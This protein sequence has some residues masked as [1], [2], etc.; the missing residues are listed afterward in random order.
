MKLVKC[1]IYRPDQFTQNSFRLRKIFHLR[2]FGIGYMLKG[3][4]VLAAGA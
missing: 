2:H 3:C 4:Y 1:M